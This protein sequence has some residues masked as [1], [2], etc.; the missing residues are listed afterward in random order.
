MVIASTL[1][2]LSPSSPS[3]AIEVTEEHEVFRRTVREF[4]EKEVAPRARWIDRENEM[5]MDLVR[6]A[7]SLGLFGVSFAEEYGGA[8][9]DDLSLVIATEEIARVSAAFSTVVGANYLVTVPL[10]L[11]GN[12][13]QK[14]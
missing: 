4:A 3:Y 14:Q 10:N 11:Y 6:R 2:T 12:E 1:S 7:G 5:D 9:G 13:M 8:G